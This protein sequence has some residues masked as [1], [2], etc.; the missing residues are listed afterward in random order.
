MGFPIPRIIFLNSESCSENTP[1]LSQSSGNGLSTL[2]AFFLKLGW[3]PGFWMLDRSKCSRFGAS[4][5]HTTGFSWWLGKL[6]C[7]SE[8]ASF[9]SSAPSFVSRRGQIAGLDLQRCT[10]F[11]FW[12][13]CFVGSLFCFLM[14]V[15][16]FRS[17]ARIKQ[18]RTWW[19]S[20]L[21]MRLASLWTAERPWS[22]WWDDLSMLD[23]LALYGRVTPAQAKLESEK[24][25]GLTRIAWPKKTKNYLRQLFI[26]ILN[27]S[28]LTWTLYSG[29]QDSSPKCRGMAAKY[30]QWQRHWGAWVDLVGRWWGFVSY[31]VQCLPPSATLDSEISFFLQGERNV[32]EKSS[33]KPC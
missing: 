29:G 5:F 17:R 4:S 19:P 1:E 10:Y 14:E 32:E 11:W 7:V 9:V 26:E 23:S 12:L 6:G 8:V 15:T 30:L 33:R 20:S 18:I 22:I 25:G 31:Y 27:A 13:L 24:L 28:M 2:R 21:K 16:F 3:S